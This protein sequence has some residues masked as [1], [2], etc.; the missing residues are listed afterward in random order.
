M[1]DTT[2]P[3]LPGYSFPDPAKDKFHKS[4][5]LGYRN[6]YVI[7]KTNDVAGLTQADIDELANTQPSLTYGKAKPEPPTNF[8]PAHVAFDKKVGKCLISI[9]KI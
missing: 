4:Q 8:V 1:G 2:L 5:T 9:L 3:F 6:G 7:P